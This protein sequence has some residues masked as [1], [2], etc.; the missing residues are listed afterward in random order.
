MT[1]V[2]NMLLYV[3]YTINMN[4]LYYTDYIDVTIMT[5]TLTLC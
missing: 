4:K 3:N 5:C 1:K 2:L